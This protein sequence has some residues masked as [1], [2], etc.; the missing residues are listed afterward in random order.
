MTDKSIRKGATFSATKANLPKEWLDQIFALSLDLICVADITTTT[1]LK[2]N[3]AFM[4][5]LGFSEKELLGRP[6]YDFIHPDDLKATRSVVENELREGNTVIRFQ[7]RYICKDGS[8]RW[9]R[10]V[11]HPRPDQGITYAIANDITETK[12]IEETLKGEKTL[13]KTIF[14]HLPIM[15]AFYDAN[16]DRLYLNREFAKKIGWRPEEVDHITLFEN[17]YPDPSYRQ[18]VLAWIDEKH[19]LWKEFQVTS[20]SGKVIPSEWSYLRLANGTRIAIGIDITERKRAEEALRKK[21]AMLANIAS[22]VPGMLFRFMRKPDGTFSLPYS[23]HGVKEIFGCLPEEVSDDFSP[24]FNVIFPED[25][26]KVIRTINE[27]VKDLSQWICEYRVQLPGEPVKWI[28]GN[29]IP[30]KLPDGSIVWSGYN[31]DITYRK[32]AEKEKA[33][34]EAHLRQAQKMESVGRLAGGVAHDFNNMLSVILGYAEMALEKVSPSDSIYDDLTEIIVAAN[35]SSEV[36]RQLLAFARRQT[37]IPKVLDLNEIVSGMLKMLERLLGEDVHLSWTPAADLWLVK[38]DP[39]QVDQILANLCINARDAI[40]GNGNIHIE[41]YNRTLRAEDC[42]PHVGC[43]PGEYVCLAVCD[44]GCGMNQ[45]VLAR[46]FEPFFTTKSVGEGTGLG[47]AMVYGAVQQNN[48]FIDTQSEPDK[49]TRIAIH[50]PRH[51]GELTL[52][53]T[54]KSSG[55]P[56][57]IQGTILLVEDEKAVLTMTAKILEKQGYTVLAANA[58]HEA[59][60]LAREHTARIHLLITDVIMPQMNGRELWDQL[61]TWRPEIKCL[62]MSGYTANVIVNR[63][64]LEEGVNYI[65]KPF[66]T[67]TLISKV[68]EVLGNGV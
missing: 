14:D 1:F 63:G 50:L 28:F 33:D 47:L 56:I 27:S 3:P 57:T 16:A 9:L 10:W 46:I 19:S 8:Y 67:K 58:P 40:A 17:I 13:F 49:G 38:V 59:I 18:H 60:R 55:H 24:V 21:D 42:A 39:S 12:N 11:S 43:V 20:K 30:E 37:V 53:N 25:Q 31:M 62:F 61:R 2:V 64:V 66:V 48:G 52:G 5:T 54:E 29:S 41:T 45:D 22:Q 26:S 36:T 6:F 68:Y 4:N 7:N 65:Q 32:Q 35:R 51:V 44:D 15:I 34:L 23:S